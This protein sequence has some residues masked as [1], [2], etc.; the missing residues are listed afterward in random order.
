VSPGAFCAQNVEPGKDI[1]T[2]TD[3]TINNDTDKDREFS[4]EVVPA[5]KTSTESLKGYSPMPDTAWLSLEKTQVMVPAHGE[6]KSRLFIHIP[7]E[8]RYYN[9][10]W[11]VSCLIQYIG[12][13]GLFQEAIQT[14]YL[15]E[16]KSKAPVTLR[17]DGNMAVVPGVIKATGTDSKVRFKLFNNTAEKH[18]YTIKTFKPENNTGKTEVSSTPGLSWVKKISWVSPVSKKVN[19]G[20]GM[21]KDVEL[22]M[23]VPKSELKDGK[24]VEAV[25]FIDS[26]DGEQRFV[27]VQVE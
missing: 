7:D 6:A 11:A 22:K 26:D 23:Q 5:R 12:Q 3:V 24:G 25:I 14:L 2:G 13:K 27:R 1:D 21:E 20:P 16:T 15:F 10:K 9:Q 17:P 8:E 18:T 19:V 4:I